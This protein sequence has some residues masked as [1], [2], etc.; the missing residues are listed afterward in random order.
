MMS[1]DFAEATDAFF[2]RSFADSSRMGIFRG[3]ATADT[4]TLCNRAWDENVELVEIPFQSPESLDT[5][6][7]VIAAGRTRGKF[8]GAGTIVD[9]E[10]VRTVADLGAQFCVSPGFDLEVAIACERAGLFHLPGVA[11]A[12]EISDVSKHGYVWMKAFPASLLGPEWITAMRG[13]F[14]D[15][16]FV[17]TGGM[18]SENSAAYLSAGARGVAIGARWTS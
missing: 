12:S 15:V 8:V 10:Q 17:C 5:L 3:I 11:T 18:S 1:T 9:A 16:K 14:P 7:A 2:E 13:P 6:A 4:L